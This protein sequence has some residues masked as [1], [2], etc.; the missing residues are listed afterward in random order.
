MELSSSFDIKKG[1]VV[2]GWSILGKDPDSGMLTEV[3]SMVERTEMKVG[4]AR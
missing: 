3:K 1:K 4:I 2:T